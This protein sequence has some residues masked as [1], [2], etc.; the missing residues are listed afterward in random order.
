MLGAQVTGATL[1]IVGA[2][3]IG[4]AMALMSRG[5]RMPVLYAGRRVNETLERELGAK[6]V[7]LDELLRQSD[8]ISIHLALNKD[9]RHRIGRAELEKMKP[10]AI[11]VNTARGPIID[12]S[13]LVDA[14]R[15]RRIAAAG[16]DVYENE[17]KLTPGFLELENV[18][19][20]PHLG[21]ATR[22]TREAMA[23]LAARNVVAVLKGEKP[24]TP[25]NQM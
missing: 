1:G 12:E 10:T 24:I 9:T 4:T 22:T 20:S 3:R 8:F 5:F 11:L 2:G 16:L 17:P 19:L 18:I 13:A 7:E 6:R 14:L 23:A 21:S 15:N 25:V